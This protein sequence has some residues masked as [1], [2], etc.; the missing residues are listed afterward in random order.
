MNEQG[1]VEDSVVMPDATQS[2]LMKISSAILSIA[3]SADNLGSGVPYGTRSRNRANS[4]RPNYAED[5][6][7][8][9][10]YEAP[11][12]GNGCKVPRGSEVVNPLET[13][14]FLANSRRASHTDHE[15]RN[16]GHKS[17][18]EC[19]PGN[20]TIPVAS[21]LEQGQSTTNKK[22][23]AASQM[24][25]PSKS[26][27]QSITMHSKVPRSCAASHIAA[28]FRETNMMGFENCGGRLMG[29]NLVADDGTVLQ[30]NDHVYL[31][32]EP[33]GE[34]YY[35]GRIM[36]FLHANNDSSQPIDSLRLNWFYRPKDI[37]RKANDTRQVYATMHSEIS[38]LTSLRGK[39]QIKHKSEIDKL[40]D[41]RRTP[42]CF[43]YEKLFDR[44]IHRFYD[45][46][47]TSEVI[48]VPVDVKRVLDERWKFILVETGRG[49]DLTSAVK[50]CKRCNKYCA[51]N[52]SVDCA[53]CQNTYHMIC[54]NPP[55]L[56]KPSRGFAWACG[57]CSKAQ[58]KKLE[59]RNTPKING[60]N[61]RDE[62]DDFID[63][64]T[65]SQMAPGDL[66]ETEQ[67]SPLVTSDVDV[68][69]KPGT[70][71][72]SRQISLWP[73]RYLGIYC[74][75]QDALDYDGWIYP[76]ACSRIG[77]RHQANVPAW[78]GRPVEYVKPPEIKKKGLKG[79]GYKKDPKPS[80][81]ISTS[82]E[83][84]KYSRD[85][86]P[87][88]VLDQPPGYISR[89]EDYND[90]TD[91]RCTAQL[92]Y[93]FP[94]PNELP[95][96]IIG[97]R[98]P[99]EVNVAEREQYIFDYMGQAT[100]LAKSLGLPPLSTNLLDIALETLYI[101]N[102][103]SEK[104]LKALLEADRK[105]FK[106]PM[107]SPAEIKKFEDG[108]AKFGSECLSIKKHVKTID[109]ADIV[110]FYYTWKK[111]ERGKQI[112]GNYP[113]RKEKKEAKKGKND[114]LTSSKLQDDIA[115]EHDD[116]AYDNNKVIRK[117]KVFQCKFCNTKNSR[118]WRRAPITSAVG[119]TSENSNLKGSTKD[120]GPQDVVALCRRCAELW[121]RYAIQWE[122]VD[123]MAK[124]VAQTG[125]R[126]SKRKVDEE[127]LK[128]LVAANEVSNQ[129]T[130]SASKINCS[131]SGASR[132]S[133]SSGLDA[134]RKKIRASTDKEPSEMVIESLQA[135]SKKKSLSYKSAIF[136]LSSPELSQENM[137]S[138]A[139]CSEIEPLTDQCISCKDCRMTVHRNCYGVVDNRN[140]SK[141]TCDMC[142]NDKNPQVSVQYKCV[143][144]PI[145]FTERKCAESLKVSN[146]KKLEKDLVKDRFKREGNQEVTDCFRS[147]QR[148]KNKP[149]N[150][151]E[152]LK[153]TANN[154]WV[155]VT[156]AVFTPEVKFGNSK[157]LEPSEGIPLIPASRY[158]GICEVCKSNSRGACV[159]CHECHIPVHVECAHQ[160]G[161]LLGFEVLPVKASSDQKNIVNIDN[162]IGTMTAAIWCKDHTPTKTTVYRMQHI[163][164]TTGLNTLQ[165]FVQNFKQADL[166]LT[167]TVRKAT[168]INLS[169][170]IASK[171]ND[172]SPKYHIL[173]HLNGTCN[174]AYS[175]G[176]SQTSLDHDVIVKPEITKKVCVTCDVDISPKWW[177]YQGENSRSSILTLP[178]TSTEINGEIHSLPQKAYIRNSPKNIQ[179]RILRENHAELAA[180]A[181]DQNSIVTP[182][183][184]MVNSKSIAYQ[185]HQC[186][187][188]KIEKKITTTTPFMNSVDPSQSPF[189]TSSSA[190]VQNARVELDMIQSVKTSYSWPLLPS[191]Q[192]QNG[193]LNDQQNS[194]RQ[195][196]SIVQ[197]ISNANQANLGLSNSNVRPDELPHSLNSQIRQNSSPNS[198]H[199][200]HFSPLS[201]GYSSSQRSIGLSDNSLQ[202]SQYTSYPISRPTPLS[203]QNIVTGSPPTLPLD[204]LFSR[205]NGTLIQHHSIGSHQNSL[206]SHDE[207]LCR[208]H[209]QNLSLGPVDHSN[210]SKINGGASA[211]PS[212]RNLLH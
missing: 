160:A 113:I 69:L 89:G 184:S 16:D 61:N 123:E 58:E 121:R 104:A 64:E 67:N 110:R 21:N 78:Y 175:P 84:D 6:I 73:F 194:N 197:S 119:S 126:A 17:V 170:S 211:S 157:A 135:I 63:E 116:S 151:R 19:L 103:D 185:C 9:T 34:P 83:T 86:R 32:S 109:R 44:Y 85:Q 146:K 208:A 74:R 112:W 65:D 11:A 99:I 209:D 43:W 200:G 20:S 149:V 130:H 22:R 174:S 148:D 46:I 178:I 3:P 158:K 40:D 82:S 4:S 176:L 145:E 51:S 111:T 179:E 95:K 37:G 196:H 23:K 195:N 198:H 186:H 115:D 108:V 190:A 173:P 127:I 125:G 118:Q 96:S 35:L 156:C 80:K 171:T 27:S 36:E 155:H 45:V 75:V 56:K 169:T 55:L 137:M 88:W 203:P 177:P 7:I 163:V 114:A 68:A 159:S 187:W 39:C 138:C 193:V 15:T 167:G 100:R 53:V 189:S 133:K 105:I 205:S 147:K 90:I 164:N 131:I 30:V 62:D 91:P 28:G 48:N 102:Y 76:I 140:L 199:S 202:K 29:S 212:L 98:D 141:W 24:N 38:P 124:R 134:P 60:L 191:I 210:D 72:Q 204:S 150:P 57:P 129:L 18:K 122:D 42:D 59:A 168:L 139:V 207:L 81:E 14:R 153:R 13:G 206:S 188:K 49:K 10:D 93:K 1:S 41:L 87:K 52:D 47:P 180:A 94:E 201:N 182:K 50:S 172:S 101:N 144:C 71:E 33:P 181:L 166:T 70:A 66:S 162:E 192:L 2:P 31:I 26:N 136:P 117:K 143:L 97:N 154:N 79:G 77:P 142:A 25:Q 165:L 120:K 161:Y 107:L 152:P 183:F 132:A 8:E 128:E 92:L 54:I 5:K 106:E 12:I